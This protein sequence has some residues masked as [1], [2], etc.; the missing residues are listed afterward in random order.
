MATLMVSNWEGGER[1]RFM[2]SGSGD[3][4]NRPNLVS[5]LDGQKT[6]IANR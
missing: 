4:L 5:D 6:P 2:F 1:R 3:S